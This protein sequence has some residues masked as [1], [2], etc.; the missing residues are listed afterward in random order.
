MVDVDAL[1]CD[2]VEDVD[3]A[4]RLTAFV[5]ISLRISTAGLRSLFITN[6]RKSLMRMLEMLNLSL[7]VSVLNSSS[8]S[9][10]R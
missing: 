1:F 10:T 2:E 9:I 4:F 8:N 5:C 7:T 3:G 6:R